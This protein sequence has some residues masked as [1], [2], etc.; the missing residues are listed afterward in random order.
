MPYIVGFEGFGL[1]LRSLCN[2]LVPPVSCVRLMLQVYSE[3]FRVLRPG[4]RIAISDV[5]KE[6]EEQ[7][8]EHLRTAQAL[9]C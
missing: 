6:F 3:M 5:L 9:A 1:C 8:P 4:G 2:S 7:F